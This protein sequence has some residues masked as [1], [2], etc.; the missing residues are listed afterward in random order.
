MKYAQQLGYSTHNIAKINRH[1]ENRRLKYVALITGN[2]IEWF[3][4]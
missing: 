1:W 2:T 3:H 4:Q